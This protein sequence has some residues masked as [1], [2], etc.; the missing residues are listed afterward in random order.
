MEDPNRG[1]T[2]TWARMSSIPSSKL[3]S[4]SLLLE[5]VSDTEPTSL[6]DDFLTESF[7]LGQPG[8]EDS[9]SSP[10][11]VL[12]YLIRL[13]A[14]IAHQVIPSCFFLKYFPVRAGG[15]GGWSDHTGDISNTE[16]S[17]AQQTARP[18]LA[19]HNLTGLARELRSGGTGGNHL[20][21]VSQ[22]PAP[23]GHWD[24]YTTTGCQIIK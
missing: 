18:P 3:S 8:V 13:L 5:L 11:R 22:Q 12:R 17:G 9:G 2:L 24:N 15:G 10:P 23:G 19:S 14:D 7:S 16:S 1:K 21:T 20:L 4:S 6:M